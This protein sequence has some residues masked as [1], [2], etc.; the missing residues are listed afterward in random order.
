MHKAGLKG[1]LPKYIQ[2]FLKTR[3]FQVRINGHLS[4]TRL[5]QNGVP[6]GS[7][8]SVTLFA[9]TINSIA[10]CIPNS[11][12]WLSSLYVDDLQIGIRN[13]DVNQAAYEFQQV[14]E[15]I[16]QWSH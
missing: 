8:L 6:Q 10:A 1:L 5:Q 12:A 2:N 3:T 14:L 16:E 11:N 4:T 13:Y 9:L 7:V 15:N